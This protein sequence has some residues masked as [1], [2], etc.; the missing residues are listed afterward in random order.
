MT[1][2]KRLQWFMD[3]RFGLFVHW[4]LYSVLAGEW[5]GQ[6]MDYIGEW[7][8]SRYRIPGAEYAKLAE[9]FNPQ[10]FDADAWVQLARQAGM[11]YIVFTAKHH[12]GFAMYHS[13]C[14]R[15]NIVDA[16][17]FG[18]DPLMELADAC[19]R[20]GLKLGLYY[21]QDLDWHEADGGDPGPQ[22]PRNFGMSWGND[23]DFPD[24]AAK[25]YARYFEAKV[26]PQ[27]REL[28]TQYGTVG[29]I[30]FDCPVTINAQQSQEL[31]D[32]VRELQPNCLINTRI[33][34]GLGDYGSMGDNQVP[35]GQVEGAWETPATLNDTWGYKYFDNNWKSAADTLGVLAG[36]AGKNVNYLLNIGPQ[37][38]GAFPAASVSILREIGAWMSV[39]GD[40]IHNARQSPYPY[41]FDWGAV[42]QHLGVDGQT[43]RLNLLFRNWPAS[44]FTL[45]GLRTRVV[46]ACTKTASA[47]PTPRREIGFTQ[48]IDPD[49]HKTALTLDLPREAPA[50]LMPVVTL[51]LEGDAEVDQTLTLQ[52]GVIVLPADC[53]RVQ[54]LSAAAPEVDRAGI[55]TNWLDPVD[56]IEWDIHLPEAGYYSV[57]IITSAQRHSAPWQGGHAVRIETDDT[58]I[59][60]RI[61]ADEMITRPETRCYA[62]AVTHCGDLYFASAGLQ[63]V[64][65]IAL[66]IRP[67]NGVGLALAALRLTASQ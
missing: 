66:A 44:A 53:G 25:N 19:A 9:R 60:A 31:H 29:L 10:Q 13:A 46:R 58:A 16:T 21:S 42:T 15:F 64:K 34:N 8:M 52:Q 27:V 18:R 28:L 62:Q 61:S 17:P 3:A 63:T 2:E 32:L 54:A 48:A 56:A 14:S 41:D 39:N 45:H 37:P 49:V 36:L 38:D 1:E 12:E 26:K 30:W 22:Y 55:L 7:I 40:A 43:A 5:Q 47:D 6:R 59:Q 23:W 4:G 67:N 35:S 51:E 33:G 57:D 50:E 20:G 65:L 24:Y 11:R